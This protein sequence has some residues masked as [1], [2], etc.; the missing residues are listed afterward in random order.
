MSLL[1]VARSWA[2]VTT[3]LAGLVGCATPP[4]SAPQNDFWS[5]RLALNVAAEPPQSM[6]AAFEL[7][8]NAREG[9]LALFSPLG[10]IMAVARWQPEGATLQQGERTFVYAHMDEL[11][12][13]LT[14]TALPLPALFQWLRGMA[15]EVP[16][17]S[18][19]LSGHGDGRILA[20]RLTPLPRAE[21]R[22]RL[23]P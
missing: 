17:W 9:E 18:A 2:L 5:G 23:Q 15:S 14:G 21:L 3:L 16:G 19:D 22:I 8:G 6:S 12:E 10:Q 1:H 7:R 13:Q 11:T 4:P 20:Q